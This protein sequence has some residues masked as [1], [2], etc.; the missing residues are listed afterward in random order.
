MPKSLIQTFN[1]LSLH[2]NNKFLFTILNTVAILPKYFYEVLT[3]PPMYNLSGGNKKKESLYFWN[4]NNN[5]KVVV[6]RWID[7]NYTAKVIMSVRVLKKVLPFEESIHCDNH[8]KNH[9]LIWKN[10]NFNVN[11]FRR[12][13]IS[14]VKAS[15]Y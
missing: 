8:K 2:K 6:E 12:I 9:A 1:D 7:S 14:M 13:R 10:K 3:R 11:N 4:R 5:T 15:P